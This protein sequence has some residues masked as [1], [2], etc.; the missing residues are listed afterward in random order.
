MVNGTPRI[1]GTLLALDLLKPTMSV[2]AA[3]SGVL[4]FEPTRRFNLGRIGKY[5]LVRR[6][7][8]GGM[9]EVFEARHARLGK[10]VAI[11]RLR[12]CFVWNKEM[13]QRFLREGVVACQVGHPNIVN[14]HDVGV[15]E[16][17]PYLVMEL[18]EG[19]SLD[20]RVRREGRRLS[21][22]EI[23]DVVLPVA[24]ALAAAHDCGVIHRDVKP[25]NIILAGSEARPLVKVVD[26]GISRL[27][28]G[29]D[30]TRINHVVGTPCYMAPE[31][32]TGESRGDPLTDQFALGVTLYE[33]I[34]GEP[35]RRVGTSE[36]PISLRA[37]RPGV[38]PELEQVILR[39]M[40][41]D[42]QRRFPDLRALREALL[43]FATPS[44]APPPPATTGARPSRRRS[45]IPHA[46]IL[47]LLSTVV[48]ILAM[49]SWQIWTEPLEMSAPTV[50]S[51]LPPDDP[52]EPVSEPIRASRVV[53]DLP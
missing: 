53:W 44:V 32:R 19:E 40:H 22:A 16:G 34:A 49:L 10:R 12:D 9:G 30:L 23:V 2:F 17:T 20:A 28:G 43:P 41:A 21:I 24:D 35:P 1:L 5:E 6:L 27:V 42:R 26:F 36:E 38:A 14:V 46:L 29:T 25:A 51:P 3:I 50:A 39:A 37:L 8:G 47:V 7:G 45:R 11:K 52:P 13:S 4:S 48:G 33:A 18:L 15:H 31:I